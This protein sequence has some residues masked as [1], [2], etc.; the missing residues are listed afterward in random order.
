MI[1]TALAT[2]DGPGAAVSAAAAP[3]KTST[4]SETLATLCTSNFDCGGWNGECQNKVCKC[5]KPWYG[6]ECSSLAL[7]PASKTNGYVI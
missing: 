3:P 1:L 5:R 4:T 6:V 7:A 2:V